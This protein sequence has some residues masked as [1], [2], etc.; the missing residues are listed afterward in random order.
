MLVMPSDFASDVSAYNFH[1]FICPV[2]PYIL[3][4]QGMQP[5]QQLSV[6]DNCTSGNETK[7]CTRFSFQKMVVMFMIHT[8]RLFEGDFFKA[9]CS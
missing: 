7:P 4:R 1:V 6:S 5:K 9:L 3:T 8:Q 2:S